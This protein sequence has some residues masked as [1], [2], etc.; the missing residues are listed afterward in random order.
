[1]Q[2]EKGRVI[3]AAMTVRLQKIADDL[4][5]IRRVASDW[6]EA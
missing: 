4:V 1:M 3:L 5:L 2:R 6:S